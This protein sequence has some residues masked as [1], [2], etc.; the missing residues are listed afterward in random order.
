MEAVMQ[1]KQTAALI[2]LASGL[3]MGGVSGAVAA[4]ELRPADVKLGEGVR[5]M[6]DF[7]AP[8]ATQFVV[9]NSTDIYSDVTLSS[10][11]TGRLERGEPVS[12]VAK[13]ERWDWLLVG[14]NGVGIGYIPRGVV[15]PADQFRSS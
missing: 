7:E 9:A 13:P 11:V 4:T 2:I 6:S 12:V 5:W 8:P 1:K 3:L 10:K 15:A 14:K